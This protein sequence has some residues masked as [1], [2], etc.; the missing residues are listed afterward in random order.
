MSL[1]IFKTG[2]DGYLLVPPDATVSNQVIGDVVVTVL[3][4]TPLTSLSLSGWAANGLLRN[5]KK[6]VLDVI[7]TTVEEIRGMQRVGP[8]V[9]KEVYDVVHADLRL[10]CPAWLEG[11]KTKYNDRNY[12]QK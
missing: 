3:A 9:C 10:R 2:E 1:T 7:R 11:S 8:V 12:R 4:H 5:K 6:T